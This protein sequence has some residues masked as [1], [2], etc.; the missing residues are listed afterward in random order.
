MVARLSAPKW[1]YWHREH[2]L[3]TSR[4]LFMSFKWTMA[5]P[6]RGYATKHVILHGVRGP[7]GGL[8]SGLPLGGVV[9][10]LRCLLYWTE[11]D[12]F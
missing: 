9:E 5:G 11:M 10:A 2:G 4:L 1:T 7:I 8:G 3:Q 6:K 12:L